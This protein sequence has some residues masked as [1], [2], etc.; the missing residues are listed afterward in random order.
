MAPLCTTVLKSCSIVI[1]PNIPTLIII[2]HNW[3]SWPRLSSLGGEHSLQVAVNPPH[4]KRLALTVC[5]ICI[6]N[7]LKILGQCWNHPEIN[8]QRT[9][10]LFGIRHCT[11][12]MCWLSGRR[13]RHLS[14]GQISC[15]KIVYNLNFKFKVECFLNILANRRFSRSKC[16]WANLVHEYVSV[17][18]YFSNTSFHPVNGS[19]LAWMI[20]FPPA[21]WH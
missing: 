12:D 21:H 9:L 6:L 16:L 20:S 10:V 15:W 3:R 7:T 14:G 8:M 1:S 11:N 5:K 17:Y 13:N 19:S 18:Q 4:C 2:V